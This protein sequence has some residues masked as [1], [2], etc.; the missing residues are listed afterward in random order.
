[1]S[2]SGGKYFIDWKKR[3]KLEFMRIKYLK[4]YKKIDE[5]KV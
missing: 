4:K 3:V 5:L 1:M 2:D